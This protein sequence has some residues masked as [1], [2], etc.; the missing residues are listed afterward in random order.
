MSAPKNRTV[1]VPADQ[2]GLIEDMVASGAYSS[3][4]EVIEAG[5]KSLQ[6]RD[7]AIGR[8]L[9]DEVAPVYDATKA[10]PERTHGLDEAFADIRRRHAKRLAE[11]D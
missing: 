7:A 3:A 4:G 10:D 5:L 2:A 1:T 11:R 8:W 9:R 6:E